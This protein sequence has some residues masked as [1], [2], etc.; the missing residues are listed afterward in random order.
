MREAEKQIIESSLQNENQFFED[1][2]VPKV[3]LPV[4]QKKDLSNVIDDQKSEAN[5]VKLEDGEI[6]EDDIEVSKSFR[7]NKDNKYFFS[8]FLISRALRKRDIRKSLKNPFNILND[9]GIEPFGPTN[10]KL[11]DNILIDNNLGGTVDRF[12]TR[13]SRLRVIHPFFLLISEQIQQSNCGSDRTQTCRTQR[14]QGE[15][16]T[17]NPKFIF[18]FA[19]SNFIGNHPSQRNRGRRTQNGRRGK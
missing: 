13:F 7:F 16:P 8:I 17:R 12:D 1:G 10:V 9:S 19:K 2:E 6:N 5:Q 14:T 3:E 15:P 11:K 18:I 4:I